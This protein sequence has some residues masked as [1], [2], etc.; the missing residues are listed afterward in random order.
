VK[1][2]LRILVGAC[3]VSV[4]LSSLGCSK[5]ADSDTKTGSEPA[6]GSSKEAKKLARDVLGTWAKDNVAYTFKEPD[7]FRYKGGRSDHQG[8]MEGC[9]WQKH[10]D[11]VHVNQGR[12]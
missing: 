3:V 8:H 5:K 10:R 9:R 2:F 12:G 7:E 11:D 6:G 4:M 1:T